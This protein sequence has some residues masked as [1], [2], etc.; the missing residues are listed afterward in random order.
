MHAI[1]AYKT[2]DGPAQ[3]EVLVLP[4]E[5]ADVEVRCISGACPEVCAYTSSARTLLQLA[6]ADY[7]LRV[8][9]TCAR[10]PVHNGW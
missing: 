2:Q 1:H 6:S 4:L 5:L 9:T 3:V 10:G 7:T 8:G